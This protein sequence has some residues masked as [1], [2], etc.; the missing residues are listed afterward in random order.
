MLEIPLSFFHFLFDN[1]EYNEEKKVEIV[2]K[3]P[4]QIRLYNLFFKKNVPFNYNMSSNNGWLEMFVND[5]YNKNEVNTYCNYQTFLEVGNQG[6]FYEEFNVPQMDLKTMFKNYKVTNLKISTN[7]KNPIVIADDYE[8]IDI[9]VKGDSKSNN[10]IN[11]NIGEFI[12][13]GEK[14]TIPIATFTSF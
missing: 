11:L 4:F 13:D 12:R 6:R 3:E 8:E 7:S 10:M 1:L 2:L 5:R 9:G 14:M